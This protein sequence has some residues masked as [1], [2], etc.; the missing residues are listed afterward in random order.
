MIRL[1]SIIND[2]GQLPA[3]AAEYASNQDANAS[4]HIGT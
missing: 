3:S 4:R 2:R 1:T